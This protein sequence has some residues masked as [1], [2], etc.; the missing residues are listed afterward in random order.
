MKKEIIYHHLV[1]GEEVDKFDFFRQL[2]IACTMEEENEDPAIN[3]KYATGM[4]K[5]LKK[6]SY[7]SYIGKGIKFQIKKEV[8]RCQG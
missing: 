1:N 7:C 2:L 3:E 6:H 5:I 8:V 4:L